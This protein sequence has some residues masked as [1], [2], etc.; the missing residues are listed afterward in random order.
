VPR[1]DV[2]AI[3]FAHPPT[4]R[5]EESA[6]VPV[7]QDQPPSVRRGRNGV[8]NPLRIDGRLY[9]QGL[10]VKGPATVDIAVPAGC[11]WLLAWAGADA[12]A[13][14]SAGVSVALSLDGKLLAEYKDLVPGGQARRVVVP[15]AGGKRIRLSVQPAGDNP[16]GCLGDL[17]DAFF[18]Y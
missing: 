15:V 14:R 5:V 3:W 11:R 1:R 10:G 13:V 16:A 7:A 12:D 9:R 17:V 18:M 4:T 2:Q 8:G 6:V